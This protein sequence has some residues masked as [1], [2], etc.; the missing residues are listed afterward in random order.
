MR[1]TVATLSLL[2]V[3][4]NASPLARAEDQTVPGLDYVDER[5]GASVEVRAIHQNDVDEL[6]R[7][8]QSDIRAMTD[9]RVCPALGGSIAATPGATSP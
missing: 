7:R 5:D 3:V 9:Q 1:R 4:A 8:L 6:R 2:C